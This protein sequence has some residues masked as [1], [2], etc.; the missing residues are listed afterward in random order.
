MIGIDQKPLS[1]L[2][3]YQN[4]H[5]IISQKKDWDN[6]METQTSHDMLVIAGQFRNN[7]GTSVMW[8]SARSTFPEPRSP[9]IAS[10]R[11]G[12]CGNHLVLMQ[13]VRASYSSY[14]TLLYFTHLQKKRK[15]AVNAVSKSFGC[16]IMPS[17]SHVELMS[18]RSSGVEENR[19]DTGHLIPSPLCHQIAARIKCEALNSIGCSPFH[20]ESC[21]QVARWTARGTSSLQQQ[22]FFYIADAHW[23]TVT[24]FVCQIS[25]IHIHTNSTCV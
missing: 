2:P 16:L 10:E 8:P 17:K 22:F 12:R 11:R 20:R 14:G 1:T 19:A 18:W 21:H 25:S 6:Y 13:K 5:D 23:T 15:T 4:V 24:A 3:W 9:P 7:V